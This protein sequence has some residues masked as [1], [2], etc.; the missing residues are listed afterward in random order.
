MYV[1]IYVWGSRDEGVEESKG[2]TGI[3]IKGKVIHF[4]TVGAKLYEMHPPSG[5]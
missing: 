2:E 1:Q 3:L 5:I 4:S